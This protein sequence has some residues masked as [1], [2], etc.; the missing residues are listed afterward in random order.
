VHQQQQRKVEEANK[1]PNL[2]QD[3]P[4]LVSSSPSA[5]LLN[6]LKRVVMLN[7]LGLVQQCT[8]QL[9]LN[10]FALRH[11]ITPQIVQDLTKRYNIMQR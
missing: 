11:N 1:K 7:V 9:F 6:S 4:K 3:Q 5:V 8:S 10:S 2:F